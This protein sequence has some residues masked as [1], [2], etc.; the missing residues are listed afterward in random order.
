[1]NLTDSFNPRDLDTAKIIAGPENLTDRDRWRAQITQWRA[2]ARSFVDF[3]GTAYV[4]ESESSRPCYKVALIWVWDEL[5]FDFENQIFTPQN[6]LA[7]AEKFGGFDGIILWHAYPVIGID[8]RNQFDFYNLVPGLQEVIDAFKATGIKVFL[9]YNPWDRWTRREAGSDQEN[10]AKLVEKYGFDG[11]FLDT[12]KS[13]DPTFLAPLKAVN[14]DLIVGGESA[15]Q[16]SEIATHVMSWAQW[17]ADSPVPG[18]LRARWFE[19]GHIQYQTRRWNRS[20]RE[21]MQI[22]WLNGSGMM[23]WEVV[24][25]T[26]VGWS[27]RDARM[28]KEMA[29]FQHQHHQVFVDGEWTPLAPL[30]NEAEKEGLFASKF[31][32]G[33]KIFWAIINKGPRDYYGE[34]LDG[35]SIKIP[36]GGIGAIINDG[37]EVHSAHFSYATLSADFPERSNV[38]IDEGKSRT[39]KPSTPRSV[40]YAGP[41]DYSYRNRESGMYG[42]PPFIEAW[43]PLPP[44]YHQALVA[45]VEVDLS[46]FEIDEYEVSNA[47]FYE[48]MKSSGYTPKTSHR[49]L[50]HW[51][52]G[53]PSPD[54]LSEPVTFVDL[55]DARAYAL[56][57]G[58][59]LPNEWEW[60][61]ADAKD[62]LKRRIPTVW[63]LTGSEH[64]DGRTRFVMLKGGSEYFAQGMDDLPPVS[65]ILESDWYIAGGVRQA[66]ETEKLLLMGEGLSRS[67]N[68]GFRCAY[69]VLA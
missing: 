7:N 69:D 53:I 13:V 57:K 54:Q 60:Q 27:D 32:L 20:H 39:K 46:E 18:V 47:D 16:N 45:S 65:G 23:I 67:E 41:L 3:D 40:S 56:W 12:M 62:L 6:L 10:L 37:S 19:P 31:Q 34:V 9:N 1:M 51:V 50:Q 61:V 68:I 42:E 11:V 36:S 49:F 59:R 17:F 64:S 25:G 26:W 38:R 48:F 4:K 24:F 21:E 8:S 22:A 63:N 35:V 30:S 14:P 15:I 44:N 29:D 2:D 28:L 55:D 66:N 52:A 5:L 43:K 58:A 33:Q